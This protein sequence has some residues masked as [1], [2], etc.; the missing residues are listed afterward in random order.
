[1]NVIIFF[2]LISLV[3]FEKL[4]M[5]FMDV[6]TAYLYGDLDM[7]IYMK[8]LEGLKLTDSNSSRPRKTLSIRLR[9]SL[10]GLI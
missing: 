2:Y 10:Y 5:Y 9:H 8:V 6:V 4:N 7:K 1:M 3:V